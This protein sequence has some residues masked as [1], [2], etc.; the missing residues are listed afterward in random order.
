M[1]WGDREVTLLSERFSVRGPEVR[2]CAA[3]RYFQEG[4]PRGAREARLP[5]K[6]QARGTGVSPQHPVDIHVE[7]GRE[8]KAERVSPLAH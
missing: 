8:A 6:A 5:E 1:P 4:L 7:K 2:Q 3:R